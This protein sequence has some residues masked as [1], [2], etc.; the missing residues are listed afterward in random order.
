MIGILET[1]IPGIKLKKRNK[2][3]KKQAKMQHCSRY[4]NHLWLHFRED[5]ICI[6][7]FPTFK[8]TV[9]KKIHTF[10]K[11]KNKKSWFDWIKP[12]AEGEYDTPSVNG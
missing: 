7:F 12:L 11:K 10:K 6:P 4:L 2:K 5:T 9:H 1:I 3:E 8:N